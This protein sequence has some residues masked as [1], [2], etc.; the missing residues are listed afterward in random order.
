MRQR[1]VTTSTPR[2]TLSMAVRAVAYAV[3]M[4]TTSSFMAVSS[5]STAVPHLNLSSFCKIILLHEGFLMSCTYKVHDNA[6][7]N[8]YAAS[9]ISLWQNINSDLK[10]GYHNVIKNNIVYPKNFTVYL[11]AGGNYKCKVLIF[12]DQFDRWNNYNGPTVPTITDGNCI[13]IDDGRYELSLLCYL[14]S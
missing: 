10:P 12:F 8:P 14:D 1:G 7:L 4:L 11:I 3:V 9:G 2:T 13:I 5:H 6:Q